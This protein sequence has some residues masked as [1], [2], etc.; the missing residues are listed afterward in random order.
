LHSTTN[1]NEWGAVISWAKWSR[2]HG[3]ENEACS[4]A[5][6]A[7]RSASAMGRIIVPDGV[8]MVAHDM[9]AQ[10]Y[11]KRFSVHSC[12]FVI[13]P[14]LQELLF[15]RSREDAKKNRELNKT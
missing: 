15:T 13:K 9:Q 3:D 10:R 5:K 12:Q 1:G 8:D 2:F 6:M 11:C 7:S 4:M 14:I